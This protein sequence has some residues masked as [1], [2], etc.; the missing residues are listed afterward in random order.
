M[1]RQAGVFQTA[2]FIFLGGR[3]DAG[4]ADALFGVPSSETIPP[5]EPSPSRDG[6]ST[7]LVLVVF[8]INRRST[9]SARIDSGQTTWMNEPL[10][11]YGYTPGGG[12][13]LSSNHPLLDHLFYYPRRGQD[14]P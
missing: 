1:A 8:F 13:Q 7:A 9:V 4:D 2:I 12:A 14:T 6:G 11:T 5:P 10:Y 3:S